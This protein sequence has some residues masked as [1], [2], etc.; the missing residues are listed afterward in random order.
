MPRAAALLFALCLT[1]VA[2][3]G[4]A[5]EPDAPAA[6][7]RTLTENDVLQLFREW[8]CPGNPSLAQAL[9]RPFAQALPEPGAWIL[10]SPRVTFRY[11]EATRTFTTTPEQTKLVQDMRASDDC[12][13][14]SSGHRPV[15]APRGAL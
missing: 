8:V 5:T 11:S 10:R 15:G 12:R 4:E 9:Y 1:A 2:C 13:A 14:P 6:P 3:R 7:A